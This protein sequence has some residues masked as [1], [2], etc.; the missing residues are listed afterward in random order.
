[1]RL[2][3]GGG[4]AG[5]G[6][7]PADAAALALAHAAPDPELL[8]VLQGE[9]EAI[10]TDDAPAADLFGLPGRR[11]SL[12]KEQVRIH[13]EAVGQV[14]PAPLSGHVGCVQHGGRSPR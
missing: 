5:D 13:A 11:P 2:G 7:G 14:L 10:L 1:M 6:P 3:G 8:A 4:P 12:R 9:L